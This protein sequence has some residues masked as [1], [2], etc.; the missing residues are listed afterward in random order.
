MVLLGS[1]WYLVETYRRAYDLNQVLI[2]AHDL[3]VAVIDL[4]MIA[5][6]GFGLLGI[7]TS[8]GLFRLEEKARKRAISLSTVPVGLV[9]FVL[10]IFVG[11]TVSGNNGASSSNALYGVVIYGPLLVILTPLSAWWFFLLRSVRIRQQFH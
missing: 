10:L 6:I 2:Y 3:S 5:Q 8:A 4:S 11:G 9:A 1:L 7:L